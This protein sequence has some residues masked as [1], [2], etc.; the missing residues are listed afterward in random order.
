MTDR[1]QHLEANLFI[2]KKGGYTSCVKAIM[3]LLI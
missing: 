3:L 2:A 1:N